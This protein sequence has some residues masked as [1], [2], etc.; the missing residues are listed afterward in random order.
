MTVRA[1]ATGK[2]RMLW[3]ITGLALMVIF[4]SGC[5][6]IPHQEL[7]AYASA[8]SA[9][10][11]AGVLMTE[12]WQAA[13]AEH[14][15]R[16]AAKNPSPPPAPPDPI[17]LTWSP[18]AGSTTA[19]TAEKVR[20]LAWETIGE[21]TAVL[22]A[23]N[24]GESVENVRSSADRLYGVV[25][26]FARASGSSVPGGEAFVALLQKLAE[27]LENAR[28]AAEFE[29][30]VRG[31][32]PIVREMLTVFRR[33]AAD[34]ALLRAT[35][36]AS[37]YERVD[38]EPDLTAEERRAKKARIK[39][40][41]DAFRKS[42]DQYVRLIDQTGDNLYELERAVDQPID[43]VAETNRMLDIALDLRQHWSAYQNA[44]TAGSF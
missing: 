7:D 40:A 18:P 13:R 41:H 14:E 29:K 6:S 15:R 38:L 20:L 21:Y 23:L 1:A 10:R 35:L 36:A 12:D 31:G 2:G 24:A 26:R 3:M 33:D 30:A 8:V 19:L 25:G 42:L 34:H 28:L 17:P 44:K 16:I 27:L 4:A 43:F 9:A 11:E 32:A 39:A 5:A 37:D 22:A